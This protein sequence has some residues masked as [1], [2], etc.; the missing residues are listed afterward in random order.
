MDRI[1]A[2]ADAQ[3]Q[4][5][6]DELYK[7]NRDWELAN[8]SLQRC[9]Q[10]FAPP[11]PPAPPMTGGTST[12]GGVTLGGPVVATGGCTPTQ[13]RRCTQG[14]IKAGSERST[15]REITVNELNR[16]EIVLDAIY[17]GAQYTPV[18]EFIEWMDFIRQSFKAGKAI[19][20]VINGTVVEGTLDT[21]DATGIHDV[22]DFLTYWDK[23]SEATL[24]G[25]KQTSDI[26]IDRFGKL[27]GYSLKFT[28]RIHTATCRTWE[29]CE[30]GAWVRK[31]EVK[32]EITRT[33]RNRTTR[34]I[35]VHDKREIPG[36]I[37]R[38]FTELAG[39]NDRGTRALK[40]FEEACGR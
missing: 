16:A 37:D 35:D 12:G 23:L 34:T 22:P 24:K 21:I 14:E 39:E 20:T 8:G 1:S 28:R 15:T 7:A 17:P 26:F 25:L 31:S 33:E 5:A 4:T 38:L 36:A 30:G 40:A 18:S 2:L 29:Q 27:G 9:L 19:N 3:R 11:P 6:Q 13:E 10:L 32:L